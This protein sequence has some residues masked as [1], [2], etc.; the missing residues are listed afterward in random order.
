MKHLAKVFSAE[1][2][3]I[4]AKMIEVEIDINIGLHSF[5]IV[6]LADR[7]TN[8]AKERVSSALKNS[9]VKPPS[10]ENRKITV[11]LAPADIKKT[12]SQYDLA[13]AIGYLL[14]TNQIK[15]FETKDKLFVGELSLE[16]TV[17]GIN[18]VLNFA[19]LAE[20]AGFQYLFVPQANALEAALVKG[21]TVIPVRDVE[22]LI[23]HLEGI[24]EIL[25]QASSEFHSLEE[26]EV[27]LAEIKGQEQ[28]KRALIVAAAGGHHLLFSGSPGAG[29]T[30]LAQAF[31]SLLPPPSIE[32]AMEIAQIWSAAGLAKEFSLKQK[33]PFRSPH[34]TASPV[35]VVGGGADPRPGEISL[36]HNGVLFLDEIPEFR[37]DLLEALRQP[38]E[39]GVVTVSRAKTTLTF[40][41]R[42]MLLAA[43]NPCPCGYFG[44][45]EKECRC[46]AHEVFRYQKKISG[47]LLD[48]IDIQIE[49][50]R[51][52]VEDLRKKVTEEDREKV[53]QIKSLIR[54]AREVSRKRFSKDNL[55]IAVN[56]QMSSR[57]VDDYV[58]FDDSG[59]KFLKSILEKALV[60]GRGYYRILKIARTIADLE[61]SD[62]VSGAHL[63]EAFHYRVREKE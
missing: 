56:A 53:R 46:S 61:G 44:D 51:V 41:A 60:S 47:P 27:T 7:A 59:E 49:V 57:Q 23:R 22:A 25:P 12:G 52:K 37:R 63:A 8:E 16:G 36:A 54:Q 5:T 29:K 18:G 6:G 21:I 28:A 2:E 1:L 4:E 30:M 26:D 45:P 58:F 10:R 55:R 31:I 40:P 38:L 13:I 14:A 35:S 34:H 39:A 24:E 19:K 32:E 11:N 15:P 50:P 43:M 48:R 42:F 62:C 20:S 33:R 3:G 17:R 9:N